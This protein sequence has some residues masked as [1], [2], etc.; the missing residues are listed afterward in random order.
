MGNNLA[1]KHAK[2]AAA[3]NN[4]TDDG[5]ATY[6]RDFRKWTAVARQVAASLA[7]WPSSLALGKLKRAPKGCRA[8][9]AGGRPAHV[10]VWDGR[11]W[12]CKRCLCRARA[13]GPL[14]GGFTRLPGSL[15]APMGGRPG[16]QPAG[17]AAAAG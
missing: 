6:V 1:D 4:L 3:S 15:G 9:V 2:L 12:R 8:L 17:D 10:P 7:C 13:G 11:N 16:P 14:S 5:V